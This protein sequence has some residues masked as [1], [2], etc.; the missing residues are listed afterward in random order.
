MVPGS[1]AI[2][3]LDTFVEASGWYLGRGDIHS[4]LATSAVDYLVDIT[5]RVPSSTLDF[6]DLREMVQ[7]TIHRSLAEMARLATSMLSDSDIVDTVRTRFQ[8]GEVFLTAIVRTIELTRQLDEPWRAE[9][10]IL[11]VDETGED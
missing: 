11:T 10:N 5:P 4:G 8:D 9:L 6:E 7:Q 3:I 2:K 1:L